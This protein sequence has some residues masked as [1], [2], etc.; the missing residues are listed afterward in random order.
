MGI[1]PQKNYKCLMDLARRVREGSEDDVIIYT[2]VYYI[3]LCK[4]TLS[5]TNN[6]LTWLDMHNNGKF[7]KYIHFTDAQ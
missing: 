2:H 4:F 6:H 3:N 1:T 7:I 5:Y